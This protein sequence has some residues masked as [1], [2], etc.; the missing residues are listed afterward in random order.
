[1]TVAGWHILFL[2]V[3]PCS[4]LPPIR[5]HLSRGSVCFVGTWECSLTASWLPG[6]EPPYVEGRGVAL[7]PLW[8]LETSVTV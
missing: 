5:E 7:L 2:E 1:M 4:R 8:G 6:M 3:E